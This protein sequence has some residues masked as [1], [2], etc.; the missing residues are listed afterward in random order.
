ME[1][2]NSLA[3]HPIFDRLCF[4]NDHFEGELA[5]LGDALGRDCM[6][7]AFPP[8]GPYY[9]RLFNGD[10]SRNED[11]FSWNAKVYSPIKGKVVR[12]SINEITNTPGIQNPSPA[13]SILIRRED[14]AHVLL[15]HIQNPQVSEGDI[16][17]EGQI[18]AYVGNNGYARNPH[19]HL[20]AYKDGMPLAIE[21]DPHKVASVRNRVGENW[22]L[23]GDDDPFKDA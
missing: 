6:I 14:D 9:L 13:Y 10:G 2:T 3:L 12:I 16:V 8:E 11:W 20:G 17:E 19:I 1:I 15:G 23:F 5:S 4:Y 21:F 22:W 18:I 7:A